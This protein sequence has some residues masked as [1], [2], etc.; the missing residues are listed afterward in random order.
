MDGDSSAKT[1]DK[2]ASSAMGETELSS[3]IHEDSK[4]KVEPAGEKT[5]GTGTSAFSSS[6]AIGSMFNADGAL[7]GTAQKVGGPFDKQGAIGSKFTDKGTIGGM[8]QE[9]LGKGENKPVNK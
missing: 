8:V 2:G 3:G 6:G 5:A 4:P 1:M 7:G 9:N